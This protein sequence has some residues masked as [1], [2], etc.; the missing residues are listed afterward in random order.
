M[1]F[2]IPPS[3]S[4]TKNAFYAIFG[5]RRDFDGQ[6]ERFSYLLPAHRRRQQALTS[7]TVK[8]TAPT[9]TATT[10][11]HTFMFVKQFYPKYHKAFR[12]ANFDEIFDLTAG[13][14]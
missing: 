14:C 9:T 8:A 2:L 13:A 12:D 10:S 4:Q 3:P 1:A 6:N 11:Q 7:P 5:G